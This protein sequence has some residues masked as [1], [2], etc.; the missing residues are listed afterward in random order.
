MTT[1]RYY[2]G[3]L[4]KAT[5]NSNKNNNDDGSSHR[6]FY[7]KNNGNTNNDNI[8]TTIINYDDKV[9][10]ILSH[11]PKELR[12]QLLYIDDDI[13]V[14]NKPCNLRSVPGHATVSNDNDDEE[15]EHPKKRQKKSKNDTDEKKKRI[16]AQEAWV[17]A[18]ESFQ[19][20][21]IPTTNDDAMNK[22]DEDERKMKNELMKQ[23]CHVKHK[24][25]IPRKLKVFQK[26][27]IRNFHLNNNHE[28]GSIVQW[29]HEQI[30][31]RQIPL[32]NLPKATS[33]EE[34]AY[35]Q[36]QLLIRSNLIDTTETNNKE[37][38]H[39]KENEL[40]VVHRLD[41]QTSG[42]LLFARTNIAASNL[43]YSWRTKNDIK[44][45]YLAQVQHWPPFHNNID[46][47]S[48]G[49][50]NLP[51]E[52]CPNERIK[53]QV[54]SS[55]SSGTT[56]SS[57]G[58]DGGKPSTTKWFIYNPT[59]LSLF[60]KEEEN[61]KVTTTTL[62]LHPLTG[63]THQLRIHCAAI[64]SGII[65]DTLYGTNP[66]PWDSSKEPLPPTQLRLHAHQLTFPHPTKTT[67]QN[68]NKETNKEEEE[69]TPLVF[70]FQTFPTSWTCHI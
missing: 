40:L 5:M 10:D 6:Y 62:E 25:S 70:H 35:G 65:G 33:L 53:W 54:A 14:L 20:N 59:E 67:K 39:K 18:I 34:S 17:Q 68:N 60:Q 27:C 7:N 57:N 36:C 15:E 58:G 29:C 2:S 55:S 50:I 49:I 19:I 11:V 37:N 47:Q 30:Q 38:N 22:H 28:D 61:D 48:E 56:T 21:P 12:I 69:E 1:L 66:I 43:S 63:R 44:K 52:K 46:Q 8:S 31:N 16:T 9:N 42:I 3:S 41:C 45:V 64:G 4:L 26:Y 51:L 24:S 23:L 32:L 13:I